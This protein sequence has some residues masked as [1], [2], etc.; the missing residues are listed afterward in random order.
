MRTN[1]AAAQSNATVGGL[2]DIFGTTAAVYRRQQ[3]AAERRRA[4]VAPLGT[5]YPGRP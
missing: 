1:L 5:L 4:Q 2:G 3:E